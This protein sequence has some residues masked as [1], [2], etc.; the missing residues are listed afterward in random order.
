MSQ[1]HFDLSIREFQLRA[2]KTTLNDF[3]LARTI[4]GFFNVFPWV[5][6]LCLLVRYF[7]AVRECLE[8]CSFHLASVLGLSSDECSFPTSNFDVAKTMKHYHN[9]SA[10]G[11]Y[12]CLLFKLRI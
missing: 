7:H 11:S 6:F 9:N 3:P 5:F 1:L 2:Y 8:V 4:I 12:S 10:Y